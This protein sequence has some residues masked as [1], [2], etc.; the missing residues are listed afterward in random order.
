MSKNERFLSVMA[1][2]VVWGALV[3]PMST[4]AML[5]LVGK[6]ITN[7]GGSFSALLPWVFLSTTVPAVL[8]SVFG[9]FWLGA[10]GATCVSSLRLAAHGLMI[11]AL[12]SLPYS[13]FGLMGAAN[14]AAES[15]WP[16]LWGSTIVGAVNGTSYAM[17]FRRLLLWKPAPD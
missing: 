6:K 7:F 13:V 9:G 15:L 2:S 10:V 4:T 11:G 5:V 8:L 3:V 1:S 14:S 17:T 12:L 16:F